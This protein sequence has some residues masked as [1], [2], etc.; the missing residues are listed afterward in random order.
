MKKTMKRITSLFVAMAI[1]ISM[2]IPALAATDGK[3]TVKAP[4]GH[5]LFG[6][7]LIYRIFNMTYNGAGNQTAG[8]G[9]GYVIN[10]KFAGLPLA[11]YNDTEYGADFVAFMAV[12]AN[13]A[14]YT[15]GPTG[16][17]LRAYLTGETKDTPD[18]FKFGE[19]VRKYI[20]DTPVAEDGKKTISAT[21]VTS[22][23]FDIPEAEL[24][25]YFV[26]ADMPG[27]GDDTKMIIGS[28]ILTSTDREVDVVVKA[29]VPTIEKFVKNVHGAGLN[30][31]WNLEQPEG[32]KKFTDTEIDSVV[33]FQLLTKVPAMLGYINGYT[34]KIHDAMQPGLNLNVEADGVTPINMVVTVDG[35]AL[36]KGTDYVVHVPGD[37]GVQVGG[38]NA[39]F[40]IEFLDFRTKQL[41]N[42]GKTIEVVYEAILNENATVAE[43][44]TSNGE[45]GNP[46]YNYV[47]LEFSRDP[48][49]KPGDSGETTTSVEDKA[50][51]HTYKA[52]IYKF[53]KLDGTNATPLAGAEFEVYRENSNGDLDNNVYFKDITQGG[54][55]DKTYQVVKSSR[56]GETGVSKTITTGTSG[57][58]LLKGFNAAIYYIVETKAPDG[59]NKLTE[60]DGSDVIMDLGIAPKIDTSKPVHFID[61]VLYNKPGDTKSDLGKWQMYYA[62][63]GHQYRL[64]VENKAGVRLPDTGGIGTAMFT[65]SGLGMMLAAATLLGSRKKEEKN[66]MAK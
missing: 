41:A 23:E 61:G 53:A 32:W 28:C 19:A 17:A 2:T 8:A 30:A 64:A 29:E 22:I 15:S 45:G 11:F 40:T 62:E 63:H 24:G 36:T 34:F 10:S 27:G 59:F 9:Y 6:D 44:A 39:T 16:E 13:A 14:K 48:S 57:V 55:T 1:M 35:N 58:V 47:K 52:E 33:E 4:T 56:S 54:D 12:P 51:V 60:D 65:T 46:N 26:A 5:E 25:Y 42:A 37:T 49:K 7:I 31:A 3:I 50:A 66:R 38:I 20:K 21:G 18:M 43:N